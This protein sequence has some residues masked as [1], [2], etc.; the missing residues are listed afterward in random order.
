MEKKAL[1]ANVIIIVS[2]NIYSDLISSVCVC[3]LTKCVI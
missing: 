3:K 2:L 1:K